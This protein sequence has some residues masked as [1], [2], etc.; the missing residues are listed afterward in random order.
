M[1]GRASIV[2]ALARAAPATIGAIAVALFVARELG[3]W[4]PDSIAMGIAMFPGGFAAGY[5]ARRKTRST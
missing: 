1:K 2:L 5:L 3:Q 4:V